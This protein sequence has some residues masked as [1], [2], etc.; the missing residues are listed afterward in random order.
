MQGAPDFD[1]L[2]LMRSTPDS[3]DYDFW[4]FS[5]YGSGEH[6]Q[7]KR[8]GDTAVLHHE[9]PMGKVRLTFTMPKEGDSTFSLDMQAPGGKEYTPYLRSTLKRKSP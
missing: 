5:N 3:T 1:G 6:F 8:D 7:G 9:G 2:A 4:W